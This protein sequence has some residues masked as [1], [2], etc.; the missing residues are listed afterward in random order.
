MST[1]IITYNKASNPPKERW[2]DDGRVNMLLFPSED[3]FESFL[4]SLGVPET[5][6][7]AP[8]SNVVGTYANLVGD[9]MLLV[10]IKRYTS[11]YDMGVKKGH[12]A[13]L[14]FIQ[15]TEVLGVFNNL[16]WDMYLKQ[17]INGGTNYTL[18]VNAD[19]KGSVSP[20]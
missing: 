4:K 7:G 12:Q 10:Y 6:L 5:L 17:P 15:G 13:K 20:S 1:S 9:I 19:K 18:T 14:N 2:Q 8:P 11:T 16:A 3:K